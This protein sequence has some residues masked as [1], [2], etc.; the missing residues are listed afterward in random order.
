MVRHFKSKA[1]Y[2]K[3]EA[4]IHIHHVPHK[5]HSEVVIAG[6][7]HHVKRMRM[8]HHHARRMMGF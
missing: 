2:K 8:E 7:R 4:F 5:Y 6:K 3:Y 1:G